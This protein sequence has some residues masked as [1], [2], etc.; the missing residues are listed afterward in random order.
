MRNRV[1][2]YGFKLMSAVVIA[3]ALTACQSQDRLT[4]VEPGNNQTGQ[5]LYRMLERRHQESANLRL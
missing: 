5:P 4:I 3:A 2:K 1:G